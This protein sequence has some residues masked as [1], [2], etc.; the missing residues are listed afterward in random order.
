MS[1]ELQ[2]EDAFHNYAVEN[3]VFDIVSD[4]DELQELLDELYNIPSQKTY[5]AFIQAVDKYI[6]AA[7]EQKILDGD[8]Y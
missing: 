7:V 5:L 4:S 8:D 1:Y 3:T 2:L 6:Y